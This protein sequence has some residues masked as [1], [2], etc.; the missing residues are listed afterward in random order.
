MK[1]HQQLFLNPRYREDTYFS[2]FSLVLLVD[3]DPP[4][5]PVNIQTSTAND[6]SP[7][8]LYENIFF[9]SLCSEHFISNFFSI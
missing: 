5:N 3:M 1:I 4:I 9:I 7:S 2:L 8:K 6:L